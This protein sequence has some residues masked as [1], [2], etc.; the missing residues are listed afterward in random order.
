MTITSLVLTIQIQDKS[1]NGQ[2]ILNKNVRMAKSRLSYFSKK[3]AK[4]EFYGLMRLKWNIY[5]NYFDL[6]MTHFK[7][8]NK[9]KDKI[10]ILD[11]FSGLEQLTNMFAFSH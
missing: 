2:D 6:M 11:D 8:L 5:P 4:V 7:P 1:K 10:L 3:I 9:S